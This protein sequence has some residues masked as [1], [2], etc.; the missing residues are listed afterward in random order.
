MSRKCPTSTGALCYEFSLSVY[1]HIASDTHDLAF[2]NHHNIGWMFV[3]PDYLKQLYV[4]TV[5]L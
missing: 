2:E 1:H 3:Y 4:T 5:A